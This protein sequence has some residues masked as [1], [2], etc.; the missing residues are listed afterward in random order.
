[1]AKGNVVASKVHD[2]DDSEY[3]QGAADA[4]DQRNQARHDGREQD[5]HEPECRTKEA[6]KK[7]QEDR[8]QHDIRD[9]GQE[10]MEQ[11][12]TMGQRKRDAAVSRILGSNGAG[13]IE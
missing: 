12:V 13:S 2:R 5:V 10:S 1:M 6:E 3:G 11:L 9:Y 7:R 4:R 8:E